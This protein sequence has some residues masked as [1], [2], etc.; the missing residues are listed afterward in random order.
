[1][2]FSQVK[3]SLRRTQALVLAQ[4]PSWVI[5][6]TTHNIISPALCRELYQHAGY[7]CPPESD[8]IEDS[9]LDLDDPHNEDIA[10]ENA[11]DKDIDHAA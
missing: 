11:L 8:K 4:D 7:N 2:C 9:D 10:L 6:E 5:C 3:S 1:M